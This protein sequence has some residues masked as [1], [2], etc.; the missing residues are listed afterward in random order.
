MDSQS[1]SHSSGREIW[2]ESSNNGSLVTVW[3]A[4]LSPDGSEFASLFLVVG[5]VDI[6]YSLSKVV[7]GVLRSVDVLES[8]D[9]L[10]RGLILSVSSETEEF[11]F[12]PESNRGLVEFGR[13]LSF[14]HWFIIFLI[15]MIF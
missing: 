8:E 12:N 13:V 14:D 6:D 1:G 5:L 10:L 2:R 15:F 9:G 11:G 4:D 3:L 7:L